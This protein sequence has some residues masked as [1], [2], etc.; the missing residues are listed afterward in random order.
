MAIFKVQRDVTLRPGIIETQGK[1]FIEGQAHDSS[2]LAP[3]FNEGWAHSNTSYGRIGSSLPLYSMS[4]RF[5]TKNVTYGANYLTS[6]GIFDATLMD[7]GQGRISYVY[8]MVNSPNTIIIGP[9]TSQS[10]YENV[11]CRFVDASTFTYTGAAGGGGFQQWDRDRGI[12]GIFF[13][14]DANNVYMLWGGAHNNTVSSSGNET[15]TGWRFFQV[16]PTNR[17]IVQNV[18]GSVGANFS[19]HPGDNSLILIHESP[20]NFYFYRVTSLGAAGTSYGHSVVTIEKSTGTFTTRGSN[21]RPTTSGG[22]AYFPSHAINTSGTNFALFVGE[23][24]AT[25]GSKISFGVVQ[26][27]TSVPA[28]APTWTNV[29]P[30]GASLSPGSLTA[31]SQLTLRTWAFQS[32]S[33][34]YICVGAI[35]QA[36]NTSINLTDYYIHVYKCSTAA[37]TSIQYVSSTQINASLRPKALIPV[38]SS[39]SNIIVPFEGST[40]FFYWDAANERYVQGSTLSVNPN[41]ISVDQTGRIWISEANGTYNANL[42]VVSPTISSTVTVAFQN[43]SITYSGT[44][45]DT[46]LIVN[47]YNF[48]GARIASSVTLQLDTNSATFADGTKSRTVTTLTTGNLS[49]PI[50]IIAAGYVRVLANISI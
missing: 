37:P 48:T 32:G 21:S 9:D 41:Y 7:S 50:K 42:H 29:A 17:T 49:V 27:D 33:N 47:A 18:R 15:G 46:N 31:S 43:T 23:F 2:T 6:Y 10:H 34:T 3:I 13:E 35:D 5:W 25:T 40:A 44:T 20:T 45:I 22:P 26:F 11:V 24:A 1:I 36:T 4:N 14:R 38:D 30:T 12:G 39:F 28:T 19:S 16:N 8:R